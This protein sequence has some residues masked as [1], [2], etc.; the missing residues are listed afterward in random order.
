MAG[1]SNNPN[2]PRQRMINLMYLVFIAMM[3]LNVSSEV[4][5]GFE[6]VEGSLR[7]SIDN[8]SHR[9]DI[10]AGEM[11]AYY[12]SNPEK[13]QAWYEKSKHVQRASD[14]LFNYIQDLKVR[15]VKAAD[16]KD[17]DVNNISYKDD[18]EAPS[19]IMLSPING[20]GKNLRNSIDAYRAMM[21]NMIDDT[22]KTRVLEASLNTTPPH[23]AGINN[24]TWEEALFENMPVA[25]AVTLLTKMQSDIRYA[26][27][28]VLSNLLSSVDVKDYRV[29]QITAQ[30][31]P[32]SQIVMRGSQYKAN[33]VL[34]AVDST[35]RPTIFVNG[36]MLPE[37][38]QG[39]FTVNTGATGT[40]PIKGYIEMPGGDGSVMRREFES[41]Y[42]VTDPMAS[43][44]PT[45]MNVLYAGIANPI[46]I[47]V[48]GVPSGNVTATMSNGTLTRKG[49]LWEARP[50]KVGTEAVV[51]VNA[52]MADGRS[53]EMAKTSFRVRALPDPLPFIEYKDQNG[54]MRKFRGGMFA[55]RNLVEAD[56]IQAAI[57]DDLLNVK[58][59]VLRFELTFFDS[60]GNAIPEVSEGTNFSQRQKDYI[61]RLSKGKRFYITR[62]VA[63][64]PDGIERTIP[65]IE[66]I[67]N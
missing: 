60:M 18:L 27:G 56:G 66:V 5:D 16:G 61:R 39:V 59:T 24:R 46:R 55:K 67:V 23:K 45:L 25:A 4:L 28:E 43:V 9:N 57:D 41:E 22:A 12:Q 64:G 34:S 6:L 3:A 32:Q 63:K 51:T 40:F 15:I 8:T 2:S 20:E 29:N 10:V 47:A 26:E 35:K 33:I 30:V 21:G 17:G 14:S 19:R 49:D 52:R 11:D 65:T 38:N 54:N 53:V 62:V 36:N 31:I 50:S 44:A 7:T 48:P 13:V 58:Y 1:I 42:F 37:E